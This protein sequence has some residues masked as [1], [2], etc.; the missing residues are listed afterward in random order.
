MRDFEYVMNNQ[1]GLCPVSK[2]E[3]GEK[4][5]KFNNSKGANTTEFIGKR[6]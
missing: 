2:T 6:V 5:K 1:F 4:I 3:I